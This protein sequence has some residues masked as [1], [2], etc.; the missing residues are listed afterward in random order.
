MLLFRY[1]WFFGA[2]MMLVN[3]VLWR[4]RLP[5]LVAA[6]TMTK[7]EMDGFLWGGGLLLVGPPILLGVIG[8]AAGWSDPFCAGAFSFDGPARAA[9]S[10]VILGMWA[11]GLWWVWLG[12]GADLLGRVGPVLNSHPRYDRRYSP[13]LVRLATTA[14]VLFCGISFAIGYRDMPRTPDG[15]LLMEQ[16]RPASGP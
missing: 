4:R 13:R 8:L 9:N 16:P 6:G 1:F 12:N 11:A 10:L 14:L 3:V 15:C 5:R 2:A 7:R